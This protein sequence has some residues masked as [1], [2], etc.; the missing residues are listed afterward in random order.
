[1][2]NPKCV[3][4]HL[5]VWAIDA[6]WMKSLVSAIKSGIVVPNQD[7]VKRDMSGQGYTVSERIAIIPLHDGLM[8]GWSKYGGT[9]SVWARNAIRN[10]DANKDVDGIILHIDS[11]GGTV[12]GTAELGND[13]KAA[14]K[15][16]VAYIEDLGASAAYWVASQADEIS[17][18]KN[19]LVGSIGVYAAIY[20]YTE[21]AK[22]AGIKVHVI[23]TGEYKGAGEPGTEVTEKQLEYWQ[24]IID[25]HFSE[26]RS[27][28]TKGRNM[29]VGRFSKIAD[30]R[31]F[32]AKDSLE[33]GLVD[34]VESFEKSFDRLKMI[35]RKGMI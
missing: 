31:L 17:V 23:S 15:P 34:R 13:V 22:M 16:V 30:G 25:S 11:P 2:H 4:M 8:K 33:L 5:D 18:N 26:F 10:A 21:Q 12:A 9:S 24:G 14:K 28:V 3:S 7:N 1:M 32:N 20:D 27:V 6:P 35:V 29:T 19:G